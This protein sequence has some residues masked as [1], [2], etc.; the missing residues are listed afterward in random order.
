MDVTLQYFAD[1]PNW[2]VAERR[3]RE[4][5]VGL[6]RPDQ[7]IRY[8]RVEDPEEAE[9]VSFGGS[10]TI[11]IDGVDPY[12]DPDGPAGYACRVYDG[13]AAPTVAQLRLALG[14]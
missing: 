3:L 5:L 1:C 12:A 9:R 8:Q 7:P 14:G 6:G 4:V 11:L 2:R 13:G 10:P